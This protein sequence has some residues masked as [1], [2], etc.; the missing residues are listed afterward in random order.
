MQPTET[1]TLEK[2]K[3]GTN[4][5][6][7]GVD[8]EDVFRSRLSDLGFLPGTPITLIRKALFG[9]PIE[10]RLR[11][12]HLAIRKKDAKKVLLTGLR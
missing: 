11:G 7:A 3:P 8:G 4:A 9:D 5:L 10:V 6:V 12:Y 1:I 2:L